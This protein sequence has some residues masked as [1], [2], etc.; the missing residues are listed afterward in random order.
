M[1]KSATEWTTTP[2]PSRTVASGLNHAK[3]TRKGTEKSQQPDDQA[4]GKLLYIFSAQHVLS[5]AVT[6]P[7]TILQHCVTV[8]SLEME[9]QERL[10]RI[11]KA[12]KKKQAN[13]ERKIKI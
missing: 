8:K 11:Q 4:L 13:R 9:T 5:S 7:P 1:K 12:D 10:R 2:R 6:K 3:R